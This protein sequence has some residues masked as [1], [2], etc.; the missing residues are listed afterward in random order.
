MYERLY[1]NAQSK[2]SANII[3]I[4]LYF[5]CG[6][7][8]KQ[9]KNNIKNKNKPK[10]RTNFDKL[11]GLQSKYENKNIKQFKRIKSLKQKKM[12]GPIRSK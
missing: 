12:L 9:T 7:K 4:Y 3:I 1:V 11:I 8:N 5:C 10:A 6:P 2:K